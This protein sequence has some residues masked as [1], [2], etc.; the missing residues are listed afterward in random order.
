[1]VY[2]YTFFL[3]WDTRSVTLRLQYK[4]IRFHFLHCR[5][6]NIRAD[7]MIAATRD[8]TFY[9][10]IDPRPVASYSS[11]DH[12]VNSVRVLSV[13]FSLNAIDSETTHFSPL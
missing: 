12:Y 2:T 5:F 3:R 7:F 8:V 10:V 1:M 9:Y 11:A 6:Y 13:F 4:R